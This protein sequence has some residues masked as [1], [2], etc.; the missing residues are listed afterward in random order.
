MRMNVSLSSYEE[1]VR[2]IWQKK[3]KKMI[4]LSIYDSKFNINFRFVNLSI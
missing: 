4:E 1:K 3:K 2:Q